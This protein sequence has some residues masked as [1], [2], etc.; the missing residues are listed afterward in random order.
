MSKICS[1]PKYLLSTKIVL[2]KCLSEDEDFQKKCKEIEK[3]VNTKKIT[4]DWFTLL[5][6][7]EKTLTVLSDAPQ[8]KDLTRWLLENGLKN[9][10][11]FY[12]LILR[13]DIG[14]FYDDLFEMPDSKRAEFTKTISKPIQKLYEFVSKDYNTRKLP[15]WNRF[16]AL[17]RGVLQIIDQYKIRPPSGQDEIVHDFQGW[18]D[19]FT[20]D[21]ELLSRVWENV[22]INPKWLELLVIKKITADM[23]PLIG[24]KLQILKTIEDRIR[25]LSVIFALYNGT[26]DETMAK[27]IL[28]QIRQQKKAPESDA[29]RSRL[30]RLMTNRRTASI[31]E[32]IPLEQ[33]QKKLQ[34]IQRFRLQLI[35]QQQRQQ[36]RQRQTQEKKKTKTKSIQHPRLLQS[37]PPTTTIPRSVVVQQQPQPAPPLPRRKYWRH[38]ADPSKV[39]DAVLSARKRYNWMLF[40]R[41]DT[42]DRMSD[43]LWAWYGDYDFIFLVD[44]QN[45]LRSKGQTDFREI[46]RK[47]HTLGE[48]ETIKTF[49]RTSLTI[50]DDKRCA[51]VFVTQTNILGTIEDPVMIHWNTEPDDETSAIVHVACRVSEEDPRDCYAGDVN[52]NPMDDMVILYLHESFTHRRDIELSSIDRRK[53]QLMRQ[54]NEAM[55]NLKKE[56]EDDQDDKYDYVIYQS[57][58]R[59]VMERFDRILKRTH[60]RQHL[61]AKAIII[62]NDLYRDFQ[63]SYTR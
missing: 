29:L 51:W 9:A 27:R 34:T 61:P 28:S 41:N 26:I 10:I 13:P 62:S 37:A 25:I 46:S 5:E 59:E 39:H 8:N 63:Y 19:I 2:V 12:R 56:Y 50:P 48:R 21:S 24:E 33:L 45:I 14:E 54:Y 6:N 11:H 32:E 58:K 36:R 55:N 17:I 18:M 53:Y 60:K 20:K 40:H 31:S 7:F 30:R 23:I 52:K 38:K 47:L 57:H 16:T 22:I 42:I 4:T 49:I 44:V 35:Q 15:D 1:T 3:W 43:E